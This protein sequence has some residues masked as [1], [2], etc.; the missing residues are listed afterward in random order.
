[1]FRSVIQ[2][3]VTRTRRHPYGRPH[4][5]ASLQSP[6]SVILSPHAKST[7]RPSR[8]SP[9]DEQACTPQCPFQRPAWLRS[10]YTASEQRL[11]VCTP[12]ETNQQTQHSSVLFHPPTLHSICSLP[13][14]VHLGLKM[15]VAC[16]AV[17]KVAA[18]RR[19]VELTET[20]NITN[21]KQYSNE[22]QDKKPFNISSVAYPGKSSS[23]SKPKRCRC[24][25]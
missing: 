19:T 8:C 5:V 16:L 3:E 1:M 18:T 6:S 4:I 13:P 15:Y 10:V 25:S 14:L 21:H 24:N 7:S 23:T 2:P 9:L 17:N 12:L 22:R 11:S 20:V